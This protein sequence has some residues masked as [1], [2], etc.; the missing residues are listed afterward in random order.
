MQPI[1]PPNLNSTIEDVNPIPFC[2]VNGTN[3]DI[4]VQVK[5]LAPD[6]T[7]YKPYS[8]YFDLSGIFVKVTVTFTEVIEFGC[9]SSDF[10]V[11]TPK[12]LSQVADQ[13]ATAFDKMHDAFRGRGR[14]ISME[15]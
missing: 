5:S 2:R 10:V 12:G 3:L 1:S 13:L 4:F 14:T 7:Q 6:R 9:D 11:L 15:D 8:P